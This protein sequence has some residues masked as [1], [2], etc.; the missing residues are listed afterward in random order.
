MSTPI[1]DLVAKKARGGIDHDKVL[2]VYDSSD[3]ITDSQSAIAT[4]Y[5]D[6]WGLALP[7]RGYDLSSANSKNSVSMWSDWMSDLA[8]YVIA[9]GV[10]A[11]CAPTTFGVSTAGIEGCLAPSGNG[12]SASAIKVLGAVKVIKQLMDDA[13]ASE[14]SEI[15]DQI[16]S[17]WFYGWTRLEYFPST[18]ILNHNA[19]ALTGDHLSGYPHTNPA[20]QNK[21][22]GMAGVGAGGMNDNLLSVNEVS[23]S[24]QDFSTFLNDTD[25][26]QTYE[27]KSMAQ[28]CYPVDNH[29]AA[30][31][32]DWLPC[33]RI[34]WY[35]GKLSAPQFTAADCTAMVARSKKAKKT[36]GQHVAN[37]VVLAAANDRGL[38]DSLP[39]SNYCVFEAMCNDLGFTTKI[40]YSGTGTTESAMNQVATDTGLTRYNAS[41]V[42][43]YQ[44]NLQAIGSGNTYRGYNSD[45]QRLFTDNGETFPFENVFLSY[46]TLMHNNSYTIFNEYYA[47]GAN[48]G[49]SL[50][51]GAIG[52]NTTSQGVGEASA[53][54]LNGGSAFYGSM[55]E[56]GDSLFDA[57][58]N[59]TSFFTK[60]LRG[61]TA[62]E[63]AF[64]L[65]GEPFAFHELMGDGLAQP[66][67]EQSVVNNMITQ[68]VI[69]PLFPQSEG[70]T[71][72]GV[73]RGLSSAANNLSLMLLLG[74]L[75]NLEVVDADGVTQIFV[76]G[77]S[78]FGAKQ[79]GLKVLIDPDRSPA[80]ANNT[81]KDWPDWW[82]LRI[83]WLGGTQDITSTEGNAAACDKFT[84]TYN[85]ANVVGFFLDLALDLDSQMEAATVGN[86]SYTVNELLPNRSGT[87]SNFTVALDTGGMTATT[88]DGEMEKYVYKD[89]ATPSGDP[90]GPW[91]IE[92]TDTNEITLKPVGQKEVDFSITPFDDNDILIVTDPITI[93]SLADF[94]ESG[95]GG[96][97]KIID[98]N[99]IG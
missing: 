53:F 17:I 91:M 30:R 86:D 64:A 5:R 24:G 92:S 90:Y 63:A 51:S 9:N 10:E 44:K 2:I 66:F 37:K 49:V 57:V 99:I 16:D 18:T 32:T 55:S 26:N 25:I 46:A 11:I 42:A 41:S 88:Y 77:V 29:A 82:T 34:G 83:T 62:G 48:Q 38:P 87:N 33:W 12:G 31:A 74:P 65:N 50:A 39:V 71:V 95:S 4:A 3:V 98:H 15:A 28:S 45:A 36:L 93:T 60:L 21:F 75:L 79:G 13:S 96:S 6:A 52:S 67:H 85:G 19:M 89:E 7:T 23:Y 72:N 22:Q 97:N 58:N 80:I 94:S 8:D 59:G 68:K 47:A 40:G 1:V 14:L 73:G 54:I 35:T 61:A 20:Y 43:F 56:P 84:G 69:T 76:L 70:L 27:Q 81:T 78:D